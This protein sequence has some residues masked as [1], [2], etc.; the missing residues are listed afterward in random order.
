MLRLKPLLC[1]NANI[2]SNHQVILKY[3]V[4]TDAGGYVMPLCAFSMQF[5]VQV[6]AD[7]TSRTE[8]IQNPILQLTMGPTSNS[9]E[10]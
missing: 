5:P 7:G 4:D 3:K 2:A 9:L 1:P 8:D 6:I 10:F